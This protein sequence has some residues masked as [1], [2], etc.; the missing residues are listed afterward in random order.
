MVASGV[1]GTAWL[2]QADLGAH[3][4]TELATK[5]SAV[6]AC[7]AFFRK[8]HPLVAAYLDMI[9]RTCGGVVLLLLL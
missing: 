5:D 7:L 4:D 9:V 6:A 3:L 1:M 2:L 8:L